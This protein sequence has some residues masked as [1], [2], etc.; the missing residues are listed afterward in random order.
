MPA[1]KKA[2]A[3]KPSDNRRKLLDAARDLMVEKGYAETGTEEIVARAGVTRGALYYQFADKE[4]LFAAL[5]REVAETLIERVTD[6]TMARIT[7]D[8]DD[9]QVGI[10]VMLDGFLDPVVQQILLRDGPAVLGFEAWHAFVDPLNKVL[11]EHALEHLVDDGL[12]QP[13]PLEPIAHVVSGAI[14]QAGQAIA[15]APDPA[16]ARAAYGQALAVL[17][18][19]LVSGAGAATP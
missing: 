17:A 9:L 4:D 3:Q 13:Q 8:R 5:C 7:R 15:S 6:E 19:G 16:A 2:R 14:I 18:D 11:V 10:Q 1:A 12:L